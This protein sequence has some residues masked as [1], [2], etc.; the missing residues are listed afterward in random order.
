MMIQHPKGTQFY[1]SELDP[2]CFRNVK[3]LATENTTRSIPS[4]NM[5]KG[6]YIRAAFRILDDS[7]ALCLEIHEWCIL[8]SVNNYENTAIIKSPAYFS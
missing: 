7:F 2:D 8:S 5:K 1:E 4:R 6:D 3:S